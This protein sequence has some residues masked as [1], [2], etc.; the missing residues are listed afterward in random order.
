MNGIAGKRVMVTGGGGF[1]GRAVVDRVAAAGAAEVFV[2]R[3]AAFDLRSGDG[4]DAALADGRPDTVI[5]L[6]AV[7]GGIGANRENP[8]SFLFENLM[9]GVQLLEECRLHGVRFVAERR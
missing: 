1:L 2:P 5:H 4:I 7:V 3:S 9:M 8:G 6:A